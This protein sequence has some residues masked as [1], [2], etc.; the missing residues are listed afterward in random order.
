M[1]NLIVV[2]YKG[3]ETFKTAQLILNTHSQNHARRLH[4]SMDTLKLARMKEL[5]YLRAVLFDEVPSFLRVVELDRL[6]AAHA[7]NC[8]VI[9][10]L[11]IEN[12]V[13]SVEG[14]D[15]FNVITLLP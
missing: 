2:G 9:Y 13:L 10:V 7:P 1:R 3:A 12:T 14:K 8:A 15:K 5:P 11:D 6:M 4:H